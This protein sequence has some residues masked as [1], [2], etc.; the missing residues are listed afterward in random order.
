[1]NQIYIAV[2][3]VDYLLKVLSMLCLRIFRITEDI[4]NNFTYLNPKIILYN[5]LLSHTKLTGCTFI[6]ED[7][8]ARILLSFF[9]P[10]QIVYILLLSIH[11]AS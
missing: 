11:R 7:I 8:M 1:M 2:K 5:F 6:T 10:F 9:Q 4:H 3:L